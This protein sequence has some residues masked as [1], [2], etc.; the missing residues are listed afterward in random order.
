MSERKTDPKLLRDP[1]TREDT[2]KWLSNPRRKKPDSPTPSPQE[3]HHRST[4]WSY[5]RAPYRSSGA[6]YHLWGV[7]RTGSHNQVAGLPE[8][9]RTGHPSLTSAP[10][11]I[12]ELKVQKHLIP[13]EK[14]GP[15]HCQALPG[16]WP[17]LPGGH[18]V[19]VEAAA[20]WGKDPGQTKVRYLELA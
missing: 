3:P 11:A 20:L 8:G 7:G 18:L 12:S 5:W 1:P 16:N 6:R 15:T 2:P 9:C 10:Q 13:S 14:L 4:P 17:S 19:C